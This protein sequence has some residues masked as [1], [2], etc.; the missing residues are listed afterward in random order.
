[1]NKLIY[2]FA[3]EAGAYCETYLYGGDPKPPM[4]DGMNLEKFAELIIRECC[5]IA[6]EVERAEM[7]SYV[8]KYIKAHFEVDSYAT[9]VEDYVRDS[10]VQKEIDRMT[11]SRQIKRFLVARRIGEQVVYNLI[12]AQTQEGAVGKAL[13]KGGVV[14]G[15]MEMPVIDDAGINAGLTD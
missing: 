9:T 8:S 2:E 11:E 4:L 15:V 14:A 7:G 10:D 5:E 13:L 6:D 12:R 3:T 1:M